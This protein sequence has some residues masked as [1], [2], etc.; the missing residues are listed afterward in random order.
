MR[1]VLVCVASVLFGV[2]GLVVGISEP[3]L[4]GM[5]L[6]VARGVVG[7][8]Q[9]DSLAWRTGVRPGQTIVEIV[10]TDT[11]GGWSTLLR[12]GDDV[13]SINQTYAT[14]SRRIGLPF[15]AGAVIL[16]MVGF[17][18]IAR[19]RRRAEALGSI[20]LGLAWG[21][22]YAPATVP[23]DPLLFAIAAVAL[24]AWL[25]RWSRLGWIVTVVAAGAL[26][27]AASGWVRAYIVDPDGL[28]EANGV[29]LGALPFV[30]LVVIV[31]ASGTSPQRI[32]ARL[33]SLTALDTIAGALLII[34]TAIVQLVLSPPLPLT[35]LIAALLLVLFGRTRQTA[36][37]VVDRIFFA[38]GRERVAIDAAESERARLARDLHDQPLQAIA[39]VIHRLEQHPATADEQ[40]A[41][42]TV[43]AQLRLVATELHPPVLDDFGL[44]PA[45][46]AV[47][48]QSTPVR[49]QFDVIA[50]SPYRQS[51]RPASAVELAAYRIVQEALANAQRHAR[52]S[53]IRVQGRVAADSVE[54]DVIDDG[55][56]MTERA[57][58]DAVR[59]GRLGLPSMRRRAEAVDGS[60]SF[61]ATPG[62]GTTVQFRWRR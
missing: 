40:D 22:F 25:V 46:E 36:G 14:V 48:A 9:L 26:A 21:A 8:V 17:A 44:A 29:R 32:S 45:L 53:G 57:M 23:L 5:Q 39:G 62:G 34:A 56:G 28:V 10:S 13:I 47:V 41:L 38:E 42:R 59:A 11:P 6:D 58:E 60:I 16:G 61:A 20:G 54:I 15:A 7:D 27:I 1:A 3:G 31:A 33:S 4:E 35:F 50:P 51:D 18:T 30:G 2:L 43:A 55:R 19:R 24:V 52:P 12:S 37:G 49:V